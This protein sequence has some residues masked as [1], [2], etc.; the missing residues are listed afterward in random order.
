M[1]EGGDLKIIIRHVNDE[2][3]IVIEDTGAGMD[4]EE[5]GKIFTPYYTTKADGTGLGLSMAQRI[6]QDHGAGI[7]VYSEKGVGT[8]FIIAFREL[9]ENILS[10][11]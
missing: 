8:R 5:L 7:D 9:R 10:E 4:T 6:L 11:A 2:I 3:F 1:P